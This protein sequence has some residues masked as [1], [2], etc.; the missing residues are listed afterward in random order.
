[1]STRLN[2]TEILE[3]AVYIEQK[4]YEFYTESAKKLGDLKLMQL[5]HLLAEEELNHERIF[6]KMIEKTGTTA[7]TDPRE[8][9]NGFLKEFAFGRGKSMKEKLKSLHTVEAALELALGIEKD[10]VVFYNT[11]KKHVTEEHMAEVEDVIREEVNH[12][13]QIWK[14]K[15]EEVPAPPDVDAL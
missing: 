6:K 5:F 13:L 8:N 1:M 3:L 2:I 10:S 12:I 4:G 15:T 9:M 14:F 11:L 7:P